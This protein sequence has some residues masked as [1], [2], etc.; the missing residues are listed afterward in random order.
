MILTGKNWRT[1]EKNLA[2]ATLSTIHPTWTDLGANQSLHSERMAVNHLSHVA[3]Q[4]QTS[5]WAIYSLLF[6]SAFGAVNLYH[7]FNTS[8]THTH[9]TLHTTLQISTEILHLRVAAMQYISP[10]NII[11]SSLPLHGKSHWSAR[12]GKFCTH[13]GKP[14]HF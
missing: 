4:N 12:G 9:D 1:Q 2:S 8:N 7:N 13:S 3:W 11:A 10:Q 6:F 5:V 14:Y